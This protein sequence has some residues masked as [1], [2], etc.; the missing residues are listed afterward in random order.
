VIDDG[1]LA[2]SETQQFLDIPIPL[3]IA[4]LPHLKDTKSVCYA[5][6]RH[7]DKEII[8]HQPMEAYKSTVDPGP[9]AIFN[10]TPPSEVSKILGRNLVSV[11]GAVGINN[12]MGSRVTENPEL[13]R[14]VLLDCR[15]RGIFFLDSKTAYN[16]Q[17]PSVAHLLGMQLEQRDVFLDIQHDRAS[18]RKM[19]GQAVSKARK[20]GYVIVIGHAWSAETAATLRDSFQTLENQGYSFHLLSE[21]YR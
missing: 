11:R 4:V 10:S 18:I 6:A 15:S 9:G 21:L 17:V 12:H 14:S 1:G 13:M 2:L 20:N 16:S 5:I 19:W 3:T 7:A 8:L